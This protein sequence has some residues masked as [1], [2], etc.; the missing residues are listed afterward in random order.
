[1]LTAAEA[2]ARRRGATAVE[3]TVVDRR[4]ELIAYYERRGYRRTGEVR[5]FP[6]DLVEDVP[7][8]LVVLAKPL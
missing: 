3:M 1:M 2:A 5:P 6:A 8:A 7:L 4:H